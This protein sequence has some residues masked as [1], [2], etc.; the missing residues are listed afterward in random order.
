MPS[1]D[2]IPIPAINNKAKIL[3]TIISF[4]SVD[5]YGKQGLGESPDFTV[6]HVHNWRWAIVGRLVDEACRAC[7]AQ[8][9]VITF[10]L[11]VASGA[12]SS[13]IRPEHLLSIDSTCRHCGNSQR[14]CQQCGRKSYV[15]VGRFIWSTTASPHIRSLR[16]E[17]GEFSLKRPENV[18]RSVKENFTHHRVFHQV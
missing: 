13:V 7:H 10:C 18:T 3:H 17:P 6:G 11:Q 5:K 15:L 4:K 8:S 14:M 12:P 1:D 16:F 9:Y 2:D